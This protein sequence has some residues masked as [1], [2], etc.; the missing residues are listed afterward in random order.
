MIIVAIVFFLLGALL[1]AGVSF[2]AFA[3]LT[4]VGIGIY[5]VVEFTTLSIAIL[6]Y[7][8]VVAL[9]ALQIGYF[10]TIAVRIARQRRKARD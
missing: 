10:V 2:P 3:I 7:R 1:G 9:L 4:V 8:L 5:A 6:A